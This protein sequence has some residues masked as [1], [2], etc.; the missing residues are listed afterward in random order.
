[1][2]D[3][4][5]IDLSFTLNSITGTPVIT[6]LTNIVAD[7]KYSYDTELDVSVYVTVEEVGGLKYIVF[8]TNL[9]GVAVDE[10]NFLLGAFTNSVLNIRIFIYDQY[11]SGYCNDACV[12]DY[13]LTNA[14]WTLPIT[15]SLQSDTDNTD[16]T[17]IVLRELPDSREAVYVDYE[18][19][20]ESAIQS[21]I[22]QRPVEM[23][24]EVGREINF[25]Y[26]ATK[27]NIPAH[28]VKSFSDTIRDNL[29]LSSDGIVY[30]SD[31]NVVVNSDTAKEVGFV[32]RMY[33]L[34]ELE[35]G[36]SEAAEKMQRVA[37]ERRN[38]LSLVMTRV[39]PRIEPRDVIDIDLIVTGTLRNIVDSMV[40]EDM[41][42]SIQDGLYSMNISGRKNG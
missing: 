27:D 26:D 24:A 34:S 18:A 41:N 31:V 40:V 17:D 6:L 16:I 33:R 28:H 29:Q 21:I 25:T 23:S 9:D 3:R 42:I 22:Q 4:G 39:D 32:T 10:Q 38:A 35:T 2:A 19:T 11:I 37:L 20:T 7:D 5:T 14:V 1:M 30:S 36:A 8:G 13:G 15:L 12:Y